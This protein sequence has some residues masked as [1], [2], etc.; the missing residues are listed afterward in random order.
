MQ[1]RSTRINNLYSYD[2][3]N[4][5]GRKE[6]KN[7]HGNGFGGGSV[8]RD[9]S[10]Q[11]RERRSSTSELVSHP[12]R[13]YPHRDCLT[14]LMPTDAPSVRIGEFVLPKPREFSDFFSGSPN[15]F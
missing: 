1:I 2:D 4:T 11:Q 12:P 13:M 5:R 9:D 3:I 6:G 7:E 10:R 14:P 8:R 15:I